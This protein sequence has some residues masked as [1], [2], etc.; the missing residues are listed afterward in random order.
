MTSYQNDQHDNLKLTL[1][2]SLKARVSPPPA[3][4]EHVSLL[5]GIVIINNDGDDDDDGTGYDDD[6]DD[7]GEEV[8]KEVDVM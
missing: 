2:E 5:I 3:L 1:L 7:N 8:Y 6:D 4:S